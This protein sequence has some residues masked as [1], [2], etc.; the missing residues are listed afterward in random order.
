M[1]SAEPHPEPLRSVGPSHAAG[2][3]SCGYRFAWDRDPTVEPS[4]THPKALLGTIGHRVCE[5]AGKGKLGRVDAGWDERFVD[6]WRA[7][8]V[9]TESRHPAQ[10][11]ALR[12]PGYNLQKAL[13][14]TKAREVS[15]RTPVGKLPLDDPSQGPEIRLRSLDGRLSGVADVVSRRGDEVE[16]RD[17]KS[18]RVLAGTGELEPAYRSQLLLYGVMYEDMFGIWPKHLVIDPLVRPA[19]EVPADRLEAHKVVGDVYEAMNLFNAAIEGQ[20]LRSLAAPA[21]GTCTF[22]S[23]TLRC[24]PFW[25]RVDPSWDGRPRAVAGHVAATRPGTITLSIERGSVAPGS[26]ELGGVPPSVDIGVGTFVRVSGFEFRPQ[27]RFAVGP[28]TVIWPAPA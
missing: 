16:I 6:A 20:T 26:Y 27:D 9:Y 22:C 15:T 14:K 21:P 3:L 17:F 7:V 28:E 12:W 18:G 13:W 1:S 19:I 2:L 8:T 10:G 25:R 5:L 24:E 11:P 4:P 23:H